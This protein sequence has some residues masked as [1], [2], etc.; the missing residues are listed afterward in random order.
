MDRLKKIRLLIFDVDGVLTDGRLYF[1]PDGTEMKVFNVHDG[2]GI[3]LARKAGLKIALLTGRGGKALAQRAKELQADKFLPKV[4]RKEE[5]LPEVMEEMGCTPAQ[6]L[7][8]TDEVLDLHA[9]DLAG[10]TACPADA[11]PE[12]RAKA[13]I[14]CEKKGGRGAVREIIEKV[15]K[16]Q[17]QWLRG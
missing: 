10:T 15:L 5:V 13:H 9:M 1:L 14:I 11:A 6:T 12:V 8:M 4:R 3:T 7:F 2:V 16:A 17:D